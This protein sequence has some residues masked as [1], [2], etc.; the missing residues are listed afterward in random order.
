MSAPTKPEGDQLKSSALRKLD[1]ARALLNSAR[2]DMCN[3]EGEGVLRSVG[4]RRRFIRHH[5][6]A[7]GEI[8]PPDPA[9]R[10]VPPLT[11]PMNQS[12][13]QTIAV[14]PALLARA[15]TPVVGD[16]YRLGNKEAR[17][18]MINGHGE[19]ILLDQWQDGV[20]DQNGMM[21]DRWKERVRRTLEKGAEF[22]P[23][24]EST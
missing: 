14:D 17:V 2:E 22:I 24:P 4:G 1:Q 11:M 20:H 19:I 12:P 23:A 21:L 18:A 15:Q 10:G 3:L 6:E 7:H 5:R 16:F 9:H 8:P 13:S